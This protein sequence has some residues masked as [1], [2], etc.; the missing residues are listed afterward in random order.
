MRLLLSWK[1]KFRLL[2]LITLA[3]LA[4]LMAASFWASQRLN[5]SLQAREEAAAYVNASTTLMNQ[6]WRSSCLLYTSPSPRD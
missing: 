4:L 5:T 6:W 2:I 3:S 1:Q